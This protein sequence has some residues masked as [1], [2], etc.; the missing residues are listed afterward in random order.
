[1]ELF[2]KSIENIPLDT[3]AQGLGASVLL[4]I[5]LQNIKRWLS[6]QSSSVINFL[7][8]LFSSLAVFTQSLVDTANQNPSLLTGKALGLMSLTTL[9]YSFPVVGIK[10]LSNTLTLAKKQRLFEERRSS[11][12]ESEDILPQS[13]EFT[14]TADTTESVQPIVESDI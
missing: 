8:I 7:S 6:L 4:S 5:I 12:I 10:S 14:P 13:E 9:V 1:M 2:I 11:G 3:V